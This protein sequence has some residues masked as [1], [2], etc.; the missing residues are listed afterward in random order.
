MYKNLLLYN[1][2]NYNKQKL[3]NNNICKEIYKLC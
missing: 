2:I 3:K 1:Q